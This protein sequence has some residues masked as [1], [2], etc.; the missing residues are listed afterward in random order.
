MDTVS[1]IALFLLVLSSNAQTL[2]LHDSSLRSHTGNLN[3]PFANL[4]PFGNGFNNPSFSSVNTN[5]GFRS[6]STLSH[7]PA[8]HTTFNRPIPEPVLIN[9]DGLPVE[10]PDRVLQSFGGPPNF[11]N[12][13]P[14]GHVLTS[15]LALDSDQI[16]PRNQFPRQS[17]QSP[18]FSTNRMN[19]F[20]STNFPQF[21][22]QRSIFWNE[23]ILPLNNFLQN[24]FGQNAQN[25]NGFRD[26]LN[27]GLPFSTLG[28]N[29]FRHF[30]E[31]R[32][33]KVNFY[34]I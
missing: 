15:F 9:S 21:S 7:I 34:Y 31:V 30:D 3:N 4:N 19:N 20:L 6:G 33:Q 8:T 5:T 23:R 18:I 32:V 11:S 27:Q 25:F 1:V 24:S 2:Q 14:S 16:F 12:L 28:S 26:S 29:R 22:P 10:M 13:G 17:F